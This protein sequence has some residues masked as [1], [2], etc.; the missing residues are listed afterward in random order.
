M[1]AKAK[2]EIKESLNQIKQFSLREK[3]NL[4]WQVPVMA[5]LIPWYLLRSDTKEAEDTV[6][7]ADDRKDH[8]KYD[9]ASRPRM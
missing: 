2:A 7:D 9:G 8:S 3:I 5:C 1:K 6:L 4:V